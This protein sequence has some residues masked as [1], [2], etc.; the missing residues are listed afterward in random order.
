M[1]YDNQ[2]REIESMKKEL[3]VL[4]SHNRIIK[5][6]IKETLDLI[7]IGKVG[8]AVAYLKAMIVEYEVKK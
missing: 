8:K 7:A 2:A 1:S 5:E 6:E 3:S 4:Q